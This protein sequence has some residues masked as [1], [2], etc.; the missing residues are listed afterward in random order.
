MRCRGRRGRSRFEPAARA[1]SRRRVASPRGADGEDGV[2]RGGWG[3][4]GGEGR[5][6]AGLARLGEESKGRTRERGGETGRFRKKGRRSRRS[7]SGT[8]ARGV[9]IS[10]TR[11]RLPPR[12]D[13]AVAASGR[14]G[15]APV[16][17][18]ARG[19]PGR[20]R[21]GGEGGRSGARLRRSRQLERARKPRAVVFHA[22]P[23]WERHGRS[24]S[25][26]S[27]RVPSFRSSPAG[28]SPR[29]DRGTQTPRLSLRLSPRAS[30]PSPHHTTAPR[31]VPP[32]G[33]SPPTAPRRGGRRAAAHA[34]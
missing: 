18:R 5:G 34:R 28:A 10:W 32:L 11:L 33:F 16:S 25:V 31:P 12:R 1:A 3:V 9:N 22:T 23:H 29:A 30:H 15:R 13:A 6:K 17:G 27:P 14:R 24:S 8:S 26:G 20:A 21:R 19:R 7:R 4:G 2:R